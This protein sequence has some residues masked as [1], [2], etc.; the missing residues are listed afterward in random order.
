MRPHL[1]PQRPHAQTVPNPP[2]RRIPRR[3]RRHVGTDVGGLG[4]AI[5]REVQVCPACAARR[6]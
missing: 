3:K 4:Q 6:P 1:Y 2:D 5:V